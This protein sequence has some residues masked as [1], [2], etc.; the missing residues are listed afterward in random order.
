MRR[1]CRRLARLYE[2]SRFC[3]KGTLPPEPLR[4]KLRLNVTP[5]ANPREL[6][7]LVQDGILAA[8]QHQ[9]DLEQELRK[10]NLQRWKDQVNDPT[11]KGMSRCVQKKETA[12]TSVDIHDNVCSANSPGKAAHMIHK[13]WDQLW[14]TQQIDVPSVAQK[15]VPDYGLIPPK[16]SWKLTL[17]DVWMVVETG[18][19]LQARRHR[20]LGRRSGIFPTKPLLPFINLP[21]IGK[22]LGLS[23]ANYKQ[24]NIPKSHKI[25]S[26]HICKIENLR[27]IAVLNNWWC[28]YAS[29]WTQGEQVRG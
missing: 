3:K 2:A 15:L 23:P 26:H 12:H 8:K 1:V 18:M 14:A 27:P 24:V 28:M 29:A 19:V 9:S 6:D 21:N 25:G 20:R 16:Q 17:K 13:C 4:N 22:P 5:D 10:E 7:R 11:L